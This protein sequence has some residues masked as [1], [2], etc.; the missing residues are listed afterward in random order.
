M[1]EFKDWKQQ[2]VGTQNYPCQYFLFH[3][4][5]LVSDLLHLLFQQQSVLVLAEDI[6]SKL[7]TYVDFSSKKQIL[8][9]ILL[10]NLS[11]A[12]SPQLLISMA[13]NPLQNK[14]VLRWKGHYTVG[15]TLMS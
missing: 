12:I 8:S 1:A 3:N 13:H 6:N 5:K 9:N 4:W 2:K 11:C 10:E 15:G 14:I 7:Q